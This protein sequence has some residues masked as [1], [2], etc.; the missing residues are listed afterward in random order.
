MVVYQCQD[1]SC[2][3]KFAVETKAVNFIGCTPDC[4]TCGCYETLK[5]GETDVTWEGK[6]E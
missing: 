2:A 3:A 1:E 4:P 6:V 5:I